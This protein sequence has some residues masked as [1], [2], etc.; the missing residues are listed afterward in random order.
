[1]GT[2]I[3]MVAQVLTSRKYSEGEYWD[4]I[5]PVFADDFY[6]PS[7]PPSAFPRATTVHPY[8]GRNYEL[9]SV[10]ADVRN[11]SGF[12]GVDTG[13]RITPISKPR[14]LP[15]GVDV[16]DEGMIDGIHWHSRGIRPA[17]LGDHSHSWLMLREL[18]EYDWDAPIVKRGVV[19][20]SE[21]LHA[22]ETGAPSSWSSGISGG[23][24]TVRPF[25]EDL[26]AAKVWVQKAGDGESRYAQIQWSSTTR[27]ASFCKVVTD[28]KYIAAGNKYP[29]RDSDEYLDRLRVVFGFDS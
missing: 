20:E 14:G 8:R 1:M 3:H 13:D 15:E 19:S 21:L 28:L 16:D 22:I 11:G 26:E 4:T 17:W 27:A 18:V 25:G 29:S 12:G 9:F 24:I 6:Y 5:G 23:G 10:L 2:D 7:W